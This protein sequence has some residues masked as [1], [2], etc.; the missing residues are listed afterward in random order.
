MSFVM[1]IS[2]QPC[3]TRT[4]P[5]NYL[6]KGEVIRVPMF[7]IHR[8]LVLDPEMC[9]DLAN[10]VA[11]CWT[12]WL[13]YGLSWDVSTFCQPLS[14][15]KYCKA[16]LG[17]MKHHNSW[18]WLAIKART[19]HHWERGWQQ[20][21]RPRPFWKKHPM[22]LVQVLHWNTSKHSLPSAGGQIRSDV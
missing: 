21:K 22:T 1:P 13:A 6:L 17:I 12:P 14:P 3:H 4:S 2:N 10:Q 8:V 20:G 19:F 9:S 11:S 16:F 15:K 18:T 7:S 5:L